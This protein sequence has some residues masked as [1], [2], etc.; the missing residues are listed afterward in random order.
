MEYPLTDRENAVLLAG[1]FYE[2][3]LFTNVLH[4]QTFDVGRR[5]AIYVLNSII[6]LREEENNFTFSQR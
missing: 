5:C 1:M 6:R 4:K 3:G 2:T